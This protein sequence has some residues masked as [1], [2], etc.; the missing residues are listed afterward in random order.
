[1]NAA[2]GSSRL[3]CLIVF[4][5]FAM[6]V[7]T[8]PAAA[9]DPAIDS[10]EFADPSIPVATVV[11][12][13]PRRLATLW[14]QALDRPENELKCLAAA[15]IALARGRGMTGLE[16]AVAPL[17]RTLD[18]PGQDGTVRLAAA[19]A[20]IALNAQSTAAHLL[21]HAQ[22][23]G[24]DMRNLVEPALAAW[25]FTPAQ[26]MWR[27]RLSQS[28]ASEQA[29][30]LAI[31]G[32]LSLGDDKT[33]T[34]LRKLALAPAMNAVVRLEAAQALGD[35]QKDGL[36]EDAQR[37][38]QEKGMAGN[39]A[40]LV[41]ASLLRFHR[42]PAAGRV[43][44]QLAGEAE[45]AAAAIAIDALLEFD[46][47]S[48]LPKALTSPAAAV[49]L[50]GVEAFSR[51]PAATFLAPLVQLLDDPHPEV[52]AS[53]R[54]ALAR[55]AQKADLGG[56]IRQ[57]ATKH[58]AG[59]RW[60]ALE[61]SAILLASLDDKSAAPRLVELLRFERPEVGLAAAW[62]LRKLAVA[63]TLPAQLKEID[64][65]WQ[66]PAETNARRKVM[67]DQ[68]LAQLC[69]ALGQARYQPAVQ[70][71]AR[72][73]PKEVTAKFGPQSRIGAIWALGLILEKQ[74]PEALVHALI[75]RLTDEAVIF[76]EDMGVRRMSAISL[77]RMKASEATEG[78]SKYYPKVLSVDPFPN[79]CGWALAQMGGDKLPSTG[80][81]KRVQK[82]WFLESIE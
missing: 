5:M 51:R 54:K 77:G 20:L 3:P 11:R 33:L 44:Q 50:R 65:R 42:S 60:R 81:V 4:S 64:R 8:K 58:L 67:I 66:A 73:I 74:P 29:L 17:V 1:M 75:G 68:Q 70:T 55:A 40:H 25:K 35:L 56:P 27:E 48:V 10:L 14:L 43:L 62:G 19:K 52:R 53:A 28:G 7:S 49:R 45:P 37:L 30:V 26:A 47:S 41:A 32:L 63:D 23:D 79:A 24:M 39:V 9:Q 18:Q 31:R 38:A 61:Q 34:E 46:P 69:Q 82:G 71:L 15:A 6:A 22:T 21:A 59:N 57:L 80:V 76:A 16:A 13:F 78:L 2:K 36:V 72:F 12:E